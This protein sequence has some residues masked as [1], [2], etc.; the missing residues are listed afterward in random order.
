MDRE[1]TRQPVT[2]LPEFDGWHIVELT[3]P[4]AP[5]RPDRIGDTPLD[6]TGATA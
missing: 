5:R 2:G 6:F 1:L 4:R 3:T